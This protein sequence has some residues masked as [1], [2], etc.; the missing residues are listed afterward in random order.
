MNDEDVRYITALHPRYY[1]KEDHTIH[2]Y[3][4]SSTFGRMTA[5]ASMFRMTCPV[6]PSQ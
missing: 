2:I 6:K 5:S 1:P 4:H 3:M